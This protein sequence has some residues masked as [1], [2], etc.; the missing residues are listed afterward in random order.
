MNAT[1]QGR[2]RSATRRTAVICMAILFLQAACGG[3][4]ELEQYSFAGST[5]A[6]A[7]YPPP[8]PDL[9]TGAYDVEGEDLFTTLVDAGSRAAREVEARRA[10]TRLD[11]AANLIDVRDRMSRWTLERAARYLGASPVDDPATA[12]YLLEIYVRQ[13]GID[14]RSDRPAQMFMKVEAVLLDRRTGYETWNVVVNSH[15]RLTPRVKGG[16]AVPV[17]IVTAGTLHTL[18]VEE[19]RAE[20]AGLTDFT[21]DYLTNELREDLRDVRRR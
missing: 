13:F 14:A 16:G 10:R 20:L 21:A 3:G 7:D 15:D 19:L 17:D 4:H 8:V 6:V 5:L 18:T 12:D 2:R 11:S 1:T 9:W